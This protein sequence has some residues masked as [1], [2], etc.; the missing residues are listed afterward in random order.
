MNKLTNKQKQSKYNEHIDKVK[1]E[2][3]GLYKYINDVD[4]GHGVPMQLQPSAFKVINKYLDGLY[5]EF[6]IDKPSADK[7]TNEI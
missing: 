5:D 7:H 4:D 6:G 3:D 2:L 1:K